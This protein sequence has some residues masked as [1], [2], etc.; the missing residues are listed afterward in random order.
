MDHLVI[1][2][3]APERDHLLLNTPT[4]P[5]NVILS[6]ICALNQSNDLIHDH[7]TTHHGSEHQLVTSFVTISSPERV[8]ADLIGMF[9]VT[10][11][12]AYHCFCEL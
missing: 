5:S 7:H 2:A 6:Y 3:Q 8:A 11:S 12:P 4:P 9:F 10:F 1:Q